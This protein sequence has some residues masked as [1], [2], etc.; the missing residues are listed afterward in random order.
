MALSHCPLRPL[1]RRTEPRARSYS[2]MAH[3]IG[4]A[5]R[6]TR[7]TANCGHPI[8]TEISHGHAGESPLQL[9]DAQELRE[10]RRSAAFCSSNSSSVST[11]ESRSFPSRSSC[12]MSMSIDRRYASWAPEAG[13]EL[14]TSVG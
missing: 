14:S 1:T 8:E 4:A 5:R 11:P 7:L 13:A 10:A 12:P 3:Q 9:A 6:K 2:A